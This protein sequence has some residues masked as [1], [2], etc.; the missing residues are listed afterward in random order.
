MARAYNEGKKWTEMQLTL[1]Q[2]PES[3][4]YPYPGQGVIDEDTYVEQDSQLF[5]RDT[6]NPKSPTDDAGL[7]EDATLKEGNP[8]PFSGNYRT[9]A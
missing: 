6:G 9:I 7:Y 4:S 8:K 3:G 5:D 1:D 2:I